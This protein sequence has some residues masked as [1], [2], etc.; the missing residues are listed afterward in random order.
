MQV[1]VNE[2]G[3]DHAFASGL[4]LRL[5]VLDVGDRIDLVERVVHR[6]GIERRT[7]GDRTG[8]DAERVELEAAVAA[9]LHALDAA[10]D[11]IR[12]DVAARRLVLARVGER[13]IASELLAPRGSMHRRGGRRG[14]RDRRRRRAARFEQQE[15]REKQR[16][17]QA[18]YVAARGSLP[19][20]RFVKM[21]YF[22]YG[23]APIT[24]IPALMR[25]LSSSVQPNSPAVMP[26]ARPLLFSSA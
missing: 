7:D 6:D 4:G 11:E 17:H 18:G 13:P 3:D 1:L 5:H 16:S 22:L 15:R 20:M 9:K 19:A 8:A 24:R 10:P 2:K 26:M 12:G 25:P 23:L 21:R 14:Y